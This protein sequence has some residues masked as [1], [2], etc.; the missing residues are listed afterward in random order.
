MNTTYYIYHIKGVKIG[1]T[2]RLTDRIKEQGFTEYELLETHSDKS[3]AAKREKELQKQYGYKVDGIGYDQF[4][5]EGYGRKVGSVY[6]KIQGDINVKNG[7]LAK[8]RIIAGQRSLERGVID[9]LTKLKH[10]P[11]LVEKNNFKKTYSS[12]KEA[13]LELGLNQGNAASVARGERKT[14]KGYTIK[15]I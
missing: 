4:D 10:K 6:G 11:V 15:Y 14:N 9:M 3:T 12:L 13:V 5:Y 8:V 2:K 7:H 1:C